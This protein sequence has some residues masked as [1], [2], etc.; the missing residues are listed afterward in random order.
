[1]AGLVTYITDSTPTLAHSFSKRTA[2]RC[3]AAQVLWRAESSAQIPGWLS[4]YA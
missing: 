2:W 4:M 3:R 1:M